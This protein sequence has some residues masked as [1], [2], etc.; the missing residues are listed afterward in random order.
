M[1]SA[2]RSSRGLVAMGI[3][4]G[5]VVG[6]CGSS[7]S[8]RSPV[9][10]GAANPATTGGGAL[11]SGLSSNLDSLT[12]YRFTES[13]A[14]ASGPGEAT[15][16][17][18]ATVSIDGVV[19]NKPARSLSL[20][21]FGVKYVLVGSEAWTSFDGTT[22]TSMDPTDSSLTELLPGKNYEVWFD[23]NAADFKEAG[24]E[25]KNGI[26]CVHY[27]GDSSLGSLYQGVTGNPAGFHAELWVA[28][29][30][31]YPVSGIYG[32]SATS[33]GGGGSFGYSFD[34]TNVN[35]ASNAVAAPTNV[36]AIPT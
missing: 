19:V 24:D 35:G 36:V 22:W 17:A 25:S 3:A 4:I 33:G 14:G 7:S 34:I 21:A 29:D 28:M 11:V 30:G 1:A 32:F 8:G 15:P 6:A 5:L 31:D 20:T 18:S 13:L 27:K 26:Q 23:A 9:S 12:S 16:V 2:G 10:S